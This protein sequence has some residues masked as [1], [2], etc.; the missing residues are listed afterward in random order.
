LVIILE[1]INKNISS[2]LSLDITDEKYFTDNF[3]AIQTI[4]WHCKT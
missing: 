3:V 1:I 2:Q 4:S